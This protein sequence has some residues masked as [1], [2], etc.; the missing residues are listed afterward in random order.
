[1]QRKIIIYKNYLHTKFKLKCLVP[2]FFPYIYVGIDVQP[3]TK[4]NYSNPTQLPKL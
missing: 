4:H 1:M 3:L 2:I